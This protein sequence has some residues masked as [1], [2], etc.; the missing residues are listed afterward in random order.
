M[1]L[2]AFLVDAQPL[3]VAGEG[4]PLVHDAGRTVATVGER[5][6]TVNPALVVA[7]EHAGGKRALAVLCSGRAHPHTQVASF[8]LMVGF[9]ANR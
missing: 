2:S 7:D 3:L 5:A 6:V 1:R 9:G 8:S 4:L